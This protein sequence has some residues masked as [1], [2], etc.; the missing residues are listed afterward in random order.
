MS[1]K[2]VLWLS[3]AFLLAGAPAGAMEKWGPPAVEDTCLTY[4]ARYSSAPL[5]RIAPKTAG[6]KVYLFSRKTPSAREKAYLVD[7]DAVFGGPEDRGFRCVY[8]GTRTGKL[9]AGF[10]PAESLAPY[11]ETEDLTRDF[12]VGTWSYEGNP[13]IVITAADEN[14]VSASGT[15]FWRGLGQNV[16]T[17]EFAAGA[18]I[19]G[20]E[21][22]FREGDGDSACQVELLRRGPYLVADDNSNCGGMNVRFSGILM[23]I[24]KAR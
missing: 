11:P 13:E 9:I 18:A 17:G 1:H 24:G 16:H 15:A 4:D 12:L 22:T 10:V 20:N 23:K 19:Q 8:Y 14:T 6:E 3:A 2:S 21:I 7:G 5:F